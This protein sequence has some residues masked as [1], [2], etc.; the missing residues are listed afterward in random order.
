MQGSALYFNPVL[1]ASQPRQTHHENLLYLK[2]KTYKSSHQ[3]R[4]IA[5]SNR[6]GFSLQLDRLDRHR[7]KYSCVFLFIGGSVAPNNIQQFNELRTLLIL[8]FIP[9]IN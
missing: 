7:Y 8:F 1:P 9:E 6:L 5:E 4:L 3:L 2:T